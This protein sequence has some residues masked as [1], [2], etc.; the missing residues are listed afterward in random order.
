MSHST[1]MGPTHMHGHECGPVFLNFM[2]IIMHPNTNV[3]SKRKTACTEVCCP[4]QLKQH[5]GWYTWVARAEECPP[6]LHPPGRG[7]LPLRHMAHTLQCLRVYGG[8]PM[9]D[10]QVPCTPCAANTHACLVRIHASRG[11]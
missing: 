4:G 7:V 1:E 2:A 11:Q 5:D 3:Q 8:D 10:L 6:P 9:H